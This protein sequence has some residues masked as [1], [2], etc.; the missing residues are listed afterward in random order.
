M[1]NTFSKEAR[2]ETDIEDEASVAEILRALRRYLPE[3]E[4]ASLQ[5]WLCEYLSKQINEGSLGFYI[6]EFGAKDVVEISAQEALEMLAEREVW[7][8]EHDVMLHPFYID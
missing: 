1:S 5:S 4:E 3:E 2:V 6:D 7:N 8:A